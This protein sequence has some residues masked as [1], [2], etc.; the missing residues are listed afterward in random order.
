MNYNNLIIKICPKTFN[1]SFSKILDKLHY[2]G[3]CRPTGR[4]I[5]FILKIDSEIIGGFIL[6]STIPHVTGRD[7]FF[8]IYKYRLKGRIPNSKSEYWQYLNKIPNMARAFILPKYQGKGLG[9]QMIKYIEKHA[10]PIWEQKYKDIVIG[11]DC[12]DIAPPE[13]A[14]IFLLNNWKFLGKT[15]GYSR[16]KR[17]PFGGPN[18]DQDN[19]IIGK[20]K[21]INPSWY[22][23]A[24][25]Y[26]YNNRI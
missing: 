17:V 24:K 6:R 19:P 16:E 7:K 23:Y 20:M 3:N 4:Y 13:K 25:K 8:D 5:R 18:R 14:K 22:I 21:R 12:L 9:I 15:K 10:I 2:A 1:K 11:I 26:E